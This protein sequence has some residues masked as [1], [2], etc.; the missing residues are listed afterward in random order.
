[1]PEKWLPWLYQY[2]VGGL[3][4]FLSLWAAIRG[5]ALKPK[6]ET[7]RKLLIVLV[8]GYFAFL[9]VHG[10]WIAFAH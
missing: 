1:M 2:G 9:A 10:L 3:V 5:G 4:F 6:S 7:D 8:A